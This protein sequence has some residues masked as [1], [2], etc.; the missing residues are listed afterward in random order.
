MAGD[1]AVDEDMEILPS[2]SNGDAKIRERDGKSAKLPW[3]EKYRPQVFSDIV[4]NEDTVSRL[5]VFAQHGNT[6]NIIIAGPPGVGKT[7]TILCLARTLLGPLFKDAVLELN[8][9]NERGIDVVNLPRGKHKIIILDEADSM[10]DGAQQALRRTME[11]YSQ[12]TRFALACNNTEEIIEPIQSR[13]AMLRYGKLT[14]AQVLAKVLEVCEK[15]NVSYT[16]DGMEAIVFTAQGDMR[17]AL[18]NLQ[19]TYNGFNHVNA[20][21]VFKVCD[22]P[23]PLIVKEMLDDCIKGDV[24]KACTVMDHFWKMGYSAE[25]IIS[26]VFKVCKNHTMD[27][28]LKLKFVKVNWHATALIS[29]NGNWNNTY[30]SGRRYQQF[31]TVTCFS[32][33]TLPRMHMKII[34]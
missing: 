22:E 7:T 28:K 24:S 32:G 9:S 11:I 2:T 21:N 20:E 25:D 1:S 15:E 23:H 6:P 4:G 3:I 29:I 33:K 5:G 26:N 14:D 30:G 34:V 31:V 17:Q 16:D 12:T 8:A 13:C 19:S 27:E 18:N 10:T